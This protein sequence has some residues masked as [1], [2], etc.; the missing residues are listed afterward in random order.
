MGKDRFS[1]IEKAIDH[2]YTHIKGTAGSQKRARLLRRAPAGSSP[3]AL[4]AAAVASTRQKQL[5]PP[6]QSVPPLLTHSC[7]PRKRPDYPAIPTAP[8]A[9]PRA[10]AQ[11]QPSPP[12]HANTQP[13]PRRTHRAFQRTPPHPTHLPSTNHHNFQLFLYLRNPIKLILCG[14]FDSPIL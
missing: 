2:W 7:H 4:P 6:P 14:L 11:I 12:P 5:L 9:L 8:T 10:N 13:A 1:P 3:K